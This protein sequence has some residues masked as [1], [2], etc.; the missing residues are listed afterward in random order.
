MAKTITCGCGRQ[1]VCQDFTNTCVCG[2]DY[3]SAGQQLASRSQWGEETGEHLAD[4][5]R[6]DA[7]IAAGRNPLDDPERE[8]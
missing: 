3:N 4:I 5:L 1:V 7:D 2:K 6:V 8:S